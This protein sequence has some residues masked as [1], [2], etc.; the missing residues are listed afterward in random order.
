M[1][2]FINIV[3]TFTVLAVHPFRMCITFYTLEAFE[4]IPNMLIGQN[5]RMK[6]KMT[7]A[8][9]QRPLLCF[10]ELFTKLENSLLVKY[11][12]SCFRPVLLWT[13]RIYV[14]KGAS[15]R[16]GSHVSLRCFPAVSFKS[17]LNRFE[18]YRKPND[19]FVP[20]SSAAVN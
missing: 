18:G 14:P 9:A 17:I 16:T 8:D 1:S 2:S 4:R 7:F 10:I 6:K 11:V 5:K 19:K 20:L 3:L 12:L 13:S 15:G